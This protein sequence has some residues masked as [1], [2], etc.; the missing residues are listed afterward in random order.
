MIVMA[1]FWLACI[2]VLLDLADRAPVVDSG[3]DW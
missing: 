3:H 2:A 1:I